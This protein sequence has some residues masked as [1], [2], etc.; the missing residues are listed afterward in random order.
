MFPAANSLFGCVDDGVAVS[1]ARQQQQAAVTANS[2]LFPYEIKSACGAARLN[3]V[4]CPSNPDL[5]AF[6]CNGDVWVTNAVTGQEE[7]LTYSSRCGGSGA[8][9]DMIPPAEDPLSSGLPSYVMQEEFN[10]FTGF[11]WRPVHDAETSTYTILVEEVDESMVELLKFVCPYGPPGDVEEFRFPRAG[12]ANAR[13][14]L[15]TVSFELDSEDRIAAVKC[16]EL[17]VPL[18]SQFELLEYIVRMGWTPDG[19]K[20]AI[21]PTSIFIN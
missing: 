2:S 19:Q 11:F 21:D 18:D 6:V 4:S 1:G 5:V 12:S 7:R 13:S 14:T 9:V 15:R 10:R 20:Y 8:G 17:K 16:G 3:A